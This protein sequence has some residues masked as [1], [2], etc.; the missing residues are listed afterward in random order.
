MVTLD[1]PEARRLH[2]VISMLAMGKSCTVTPAP[3][4]GPS[5]TDYVAVYRDDEGNVC[6]TW[7]LALPIAA[8]VAAAMSGFPRGRVEDC[9]AAHELDAALLEGFS[10]V[11][12]V[13][14]VLVNGPGS[15]HLRFSG[16]TQVAYAEPEVVDFLQLSTRSAGF[17]VVVD[18]RGPAQARVDF[19]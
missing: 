17:A 19:R 10:E 11:G 5:G 1:T 8:A 9:V 3:V 12:N 6:A 7:T 18:S 2:E 14:G 4:E 15:V 16:T 13:L